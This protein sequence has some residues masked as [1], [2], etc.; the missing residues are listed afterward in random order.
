MKMATWVMH[1]T[2][3]WFY[4]IEADS[5]EDAWMKVQEFQCSGGW[6]EDV[7]QWGEWDVEDM[8]T[9]ERFD[10]LYAAGRFE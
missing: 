8:M 7:E 1:H 4:T 6:S 5:E 3:D 9:E 2:S 10:E